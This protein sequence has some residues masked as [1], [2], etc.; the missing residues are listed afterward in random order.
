VPTKD[1]VGVDGGCLGED[2][3]ADVHRPSGH[4]RVGA[5]ARIAGALH[6]L[7]CEVARCLLDAWQRSAPR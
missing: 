2:R 6:A 3:R 1:H 7:T 5:Q 4:A